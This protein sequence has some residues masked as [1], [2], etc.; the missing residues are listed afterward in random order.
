[1]VLLTVPEFGRAYGR[2]SQ[3]AMTD[4]A[5]PRAPKELIATIVSAVNVCD[6]WARDVVFLR[7]YWGAVREPFT[8]RALDRPLKEVLALAASLTAKSEYG[9]DFH[10]RDALEL[11][12]DVDPRGVRR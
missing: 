9:V 11:E 12:A 3:R 8:P 4:G 1:V 7:G 6:Y 2:A 5:L 10:L